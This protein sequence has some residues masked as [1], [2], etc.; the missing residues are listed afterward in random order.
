M[1]AFH[2]KIN[3]IYLDINVAFYDSTGVS[4]TLRDSNFE[5]E[6]KKL[7]YYNLGFFPL[8]YIGYRKILRIFKIIV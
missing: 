2:E 8:L 4:A 5:Q 7:I 3:F 6:V 1:R